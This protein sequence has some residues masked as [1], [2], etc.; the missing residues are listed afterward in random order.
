V[1]HTVNSSKLINDYIEF[2]TIEGET[3]LNGDYKLG[4]K[5]AK[6]IIKIFTILKDNE[7][8]ARE[9]IPIIL[10]SNSVRARGLI[11]V[12]ALRLNVYVNDAIKVLEDISKQN[13]ILDF[14]SQMALKIYRGEFPDKTL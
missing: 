2:A 14:S 4:N 10:N 9:V 7:Q 8:L 3:K 1:K 13:D 6:K 5:M 12:D 11:A